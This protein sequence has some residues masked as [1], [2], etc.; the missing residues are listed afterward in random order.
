MRSYHT[1]QVSRSYLKII[2]VLSYVGGVFPALFAA[3]FFMKFFGLYFFE[4]TFAFRHFKCNEVKENNFGTYVK[5]TL[6]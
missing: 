6:Y 2:D 1:K 4:M 5:K 3:F